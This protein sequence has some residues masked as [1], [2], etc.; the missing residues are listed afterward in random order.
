M[1]RFSV[2]LLTILA[3]LPGAAANALAEVPQF[4][5]YQGY[6]L[7]ETG[8]PVS[9]SVNMEFRFYDTSESTAPFWESTEADQVEVQDGVFHTRIGPI[10]S[11]ALDGGEVYMGITI[12][13]EDPDEP[14]S[15]M[16]PRLKLLSV[17]FSIASGRSQECDICAMATAVADG[18][19][20]AEQDLQIELA[21]YCMN[22]ACVDY[23]E[24]AQYVAG[25]GFLTEAE[26][27]SWLT[28]NGYKA[29][30][31][32]DN[33][34]VQA[35]LDS[36]G[37]VA[38]STYTD[39]D[40]ES[41]LETKGYCDAPCFSGSYQDLTGVPDLE[42]LDAATLAGHSVNVT[43]NPVPLTVPVT[44][45]GGKLPQ[46]LLPFSNGDLVAPADRPLLEGLAEYSI[47]YFNITGL[48][49]DGQSSAAVKEG[50]HFGPGNAV[51]GTLGLEDL[52]FEDVRF[53]SGEV[54]DAVEN[55]ELTVVEATVPPGEA[56]L[57]ISVQ[58][59][60]KG[61][62]SPNAQLKL[63]GV[64]QQPL[65]TKGNG[66]LVTHLFH[67]SAGLQVAKP[68]DVVLVQMN[69]GTGGLGTNFYATLVYEVL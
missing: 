5:S 45:A 68:G 58:A 16:K 2:S 51:E 32:Y 69:T 57:V 10:E 11:A 9:G 41:V 14:S 52:L 46:G 59:V 40:V 66:T 64:V 44:D 25:S 4:V 23:D 26:V 67:P 20:V 12:L 65:E 29:C 47:D 1:A 6:M 48:A 54:Y 38:G 55:K 22:P 8:E 43:G 27:E 61:H 36:A 21:N 37:Y 18:I 3:L 15:E 53:L 62:P 7:D 33:L 13:S 17:P 28:A 24:V 49:I 19:C 30:S 63:N 34:D 35:Y 56:W 31:C 39:S 42:N 50:V 60:K